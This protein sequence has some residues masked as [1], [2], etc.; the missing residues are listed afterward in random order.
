MKD[1]NLFEAATRMKLRFP[2]KGLVNV[3]D[4]WDLNLVNLDT[5]FK[6]LNSQMKKSQEESLL[7]EKT[8]EDETLEIQIEI[9]KYIV[10]V[11]LTEK[12]M[13]ENAAIKK[14]Q[15]QKIMK[16]IADKKDEALQNA[17]VDELQKM[18]DELG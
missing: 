3:E 6:N 17:S 18:L 14:E 4:L 13:A 1:M 2:F 7:G 12:E 10:N 8:K 5:I 11:K 15:K 9:V 16:I